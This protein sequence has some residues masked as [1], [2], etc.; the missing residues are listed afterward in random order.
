MGLEKESNDT[1]IKRFEGV[2]LIK[3]GIIKNKISLGIYVTGS[4]I[5]VKTVS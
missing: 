1:L 2:N 5:V 3:V 4:F